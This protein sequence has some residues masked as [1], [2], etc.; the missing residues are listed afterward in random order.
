DRGPVQLRR[1]DRAGARPIAAGRRLS[2]HRMPA[3]DRRPLRRRGLLSRGGAQDRG[4]RQGIRAGRSDRRHGAD[5]VLPGLRLFGLLD[6]RPGARLRRGGGRLLRRGRPAAPGQ[7]GLGAGA[8]W[9]GAG[10][11]RRASPAGRRL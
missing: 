4:R 7:V 9:L 6:G 1:I 5:P 3:P 10:R 8:A 2:L 11:C